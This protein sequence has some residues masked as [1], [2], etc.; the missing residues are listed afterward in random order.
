MASKPSKK[1][2]R[3][4][5]VTVSVVLLGIAT[6]STPRLTLFPVYQEGVKLIPLIEKYKEAR[7]SYPESLDQLDVELQFGKSGFRGIDYRVN[8]D[9]TEFILVCFTFGRTGMREVYK[10]ANG[11]GRTID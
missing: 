9:R 2:S 8:K 1:Q 4:K 11:W 3:V 7:G 10:S 6:C 5:W